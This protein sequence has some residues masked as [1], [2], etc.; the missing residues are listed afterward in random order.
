MASVRQS[1]GIHA[2]KLKADIR[3][4]RIRDWID[5]NNATQ[6]VAAEHFGMSLSNLERV[7]GRLK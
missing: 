1:L 2:K 7:L 4:R 5:S 3:A 6:A